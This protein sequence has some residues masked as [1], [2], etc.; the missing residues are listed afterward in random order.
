[1]TGC[2]ISCLG[3]SWTDQSLGNQP[4]GNQPLGNRFLGNRFLANQPAEA[5]TSFTLVAVDL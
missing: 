5:G 3:I 2:F 4:L 1:M